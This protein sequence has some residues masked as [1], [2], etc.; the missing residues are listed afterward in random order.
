MGMNSYLTEGN[1]RVDYKE[2]P[3]NN[4]TGNSIR[5]SRN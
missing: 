3:I 5:F 1:V 4:V 2:E